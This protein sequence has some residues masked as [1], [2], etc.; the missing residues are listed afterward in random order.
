MEGPFLRKY[1]VQTTFNFE[2]FEIDG[3]DFRVDAA[4]AAGDSVIM[5]DEGAE[6]STS[7]AFTDEGTGYS[8]VLSATEMQAARIKLYLVDQTATKVWLDKSIAIETYGNASA[9]HAF[10]LDDSVPD[11]NV[12]QISGNT[13]AANNAELMFD[14]TNGYDGGSGTKLKI[15]AADHLTT[16][17][18][19]AY[20][21]DGVAPT[22]AQALHLLIAMLTEISVSSTTLTAKKLDGSTAAATFTLNDASDPTSITRST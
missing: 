20:A 12:A 11:A 5:K 13:T 4:H 14:G 10:D 21:A 16:Q 6:A 3:V 7:N 19:E 18:T 15:D 22:T 8:I 1:G 9:Q 17:M 2:L